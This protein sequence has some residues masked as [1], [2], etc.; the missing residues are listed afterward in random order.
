[1]RQEH[2]RAGA[3]S[4]SHHVATTPRLRR[5]SSW[6]RLLAGLVLVILVLGTSSGVDLVDATRLIEAGALT[7]AEPIADVGR[8]LGT[9]AAVT[10]TT[11]DST[12]AD[13]TEEDPTVPVEVIDHVTRSVGLVHSAGVN[14]SGWIAEANTVVTNLHVAKAGSGDIYFEFSDGEILECYTAVADR[15]MDL[16]VVRC[17]TGS[18]SA[19]AI[20]TAVPDAGT[21][22]GVVGYPGGVGPTATSGEITGERVVVRGIETVQFTAPIQ[23]GSSGSPVFDS[24]GRVRAVATFSGGLGVPI[25]ELEPLLRTARG[26]P[27]TKEGAEW[28]LRIRRSVLVGT[29]TLFVA[30]F[31]A[32]RYGRNDPWRVAVR[33]T[34]IM[35]LVTLALTQLFFAARG[36]ASFI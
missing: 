10:T 12:T 26:Y 21:P 2:H 30:W 13:G 15:A 36:P 25:A 18:R 28:R 4:G 24:S 8:S 1:M 11:S 6:V 14:G 7:E 33:W 22:V 34:V 35:I 16:A 17:D 19:I 3:V 29:V 32:R 31:F 23:P 27:A 9:T 20:D 5:G